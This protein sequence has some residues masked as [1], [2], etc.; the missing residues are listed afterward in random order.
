MTTF[1]FVI[2]SDIFKIYALKEL[3]SY[4]AEKS[5]GSV[6]IE[7][8]DISFPFTIALKNIIT[9]S[10]EIN[11]LKVSL[12]ISRLLKGRLSLKKLIAQDVL[13]KETS[14]N[15]LNTFKSF[16]SLELPSYF[17]SFKIDE[18]TII[19]LKIKDQLF[20]I[21]GAIKSSS[22]LKKLYM[23]LTISNPCYE[24]VKTII[25]VENKLSSLVADFS[26]SAM[27]DHFSGILTLTPDM[28]LN[29]NDIKGNFGQYLIYHA[30]SLQVSFSPFKIQGQVF[31]YLN[32]YE[33]AEFKTKGKIAFRAFI[34]DQKI[35]LS[36]QCKNLKVNDVVLHET[37]GK[38]LVHHLFDNFKFGLDLS[39]KNMESTL[40]KDFNLFNLE[41]HTKSALLNQMATYRLNFEEKNKNAAF[42]TSGKYGIQ[43]GQFSLLVDSLNGL[44]FNTSLKIEEPVSLIFTKKQLKTTPI[45]ATFGTSSLKIAKAKL[46]ISFSPPFSFTLDKTKDFKADTEISGE[47]ASFIE[48][49]KKSDSNLSGFANLKV[50]LQGPLN[51]PHF[52]GNGTLA[53]G[54][55]EIPETG[56]LYKNIHATFES[57]DNEVLFKEL[58]ASD[59]FDGDIRGQGIINLNMEKHF[60]F[61]F[62][63]Q[64]KNTKLLRLD[65]ATAVGNALLKLSG[66]INGATLEGEVIAHDAKVVIPE[67]SAGLVYSVDVTYINQ[68]ES[69]TPPTIYAEKKETWPIELNLDFKVKEPFSIKGTDLKSRWKGSLNVKGTS[70]KPELFG[71][72]KL[73]D[74][75]YKFRGKIFEIKEGQIAFSGEPAKKTSLYIIASQ[76]IGDIRADVILKGPLKSP[77]ISFRSSPHL[78]QREILSWILFGHGAQDLNAFEGSELN[79][80]IKDLNTDSHGI[81]LITKI[82][83]KIGIDTIDL[84]TNSEGESNEMSVKVGKYISQGILVSVNK[85]ISAEANRLEIEAKLFKNFKVQAEVGDDAAGQLKLKWK[86]DY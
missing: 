66:D 71:E 22:D 16:E 43:E 10:C 6:K 70:Y 30:K 49:F 56:A 29:L 86:T 83:N 54:T 73:L 26:L 67:E 20:S 25:T 39:I 31:G 18:L 21:N 1:Y 79:R 14:N 85:S 52:V 13:I 46:P 32:N 58:T 77:A 11:Q 50:A 3:N 53:N 59:A 63:L 17:S 2:K 47:I 80:S 64:I 15:E 41:F 35:N 84:N 40:F 12:S 76:E 44:I 33:Y 48:I 75:Q 69:E 34:D 8:I 37:K 4:I 9:P 28:N 36:F 82:R 5:K 51:D 68:D 72:F 65:Y 62:N 38:V 23:D 55:F 7:E 42:Q 27:K 81:D 78:S 61:A 74:G 57:H 60:P 45:L 19:R 24:P